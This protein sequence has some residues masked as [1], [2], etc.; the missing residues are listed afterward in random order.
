MDP[1]PIYSVLF[2]L[3]V[4]LKTLWGHLAEISQI[5]LH[6]S[7]TLKEMTSY[8]PKEFNRVAL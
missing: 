5:L 7:D 2:Y 1:E 3:Q 8:V 6:I 4:E